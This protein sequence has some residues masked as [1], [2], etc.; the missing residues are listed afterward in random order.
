MQGV[1]QGAPFMFM[2]P[3]S[4]GIRPG[5]IFAERFNVFETV[6]SILTTSVRRF[7]R[8]N[9]VCSSYGLLGVRSCRASRRGR[10]SCLPGREVTHCAIDGGRNLA[11][12]ARAR[13]GV[14]REGLRLRRARP[15]DPLNLKRIIPAKETSQDRTPPSS[16]SAPGVR[17]GSGI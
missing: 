4:R 9:I 11:E 15:F 2:G 6:A 8:R 7:H 10:P 3:V 1:P 17:F 13:R 5:K 16:Y 14:L 12:P